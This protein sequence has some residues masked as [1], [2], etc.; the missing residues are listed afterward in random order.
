MNSRKRFYDTV[1]FENVDGGFVVQLDGKAIK[2]PGGLDLLLPTDVLADAVAQEWQNQT[3]I[4]NPFSMPMMQLSCTAIERVQPSMTEMCDQIRNYANTD[5]ICYFADGP[6]DL[7]QRQKHDWG[8]IH[9]W[10]FDIYGIKFNT[11]TGIMAC[12]QNKLEIE[13]LINIFNEFDH[14][15]LTACIE[16]MQIFGSAILALALVKN[17]LSPEQAYDHSAIDADWQSERWGE[18]HEYIANRK[19]RLNDCLNAHRFLSLLTTQ[20]NRDQTHSIHAI[21]LEKQRV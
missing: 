18:D 13:K 8:K 1:T 14:F 16:T 4:I 5:L 19:N 9:Q 7:C 2:T 20:K 3:D 11:T 15:W 21:P 6:D 17:Q 10:L 12:D